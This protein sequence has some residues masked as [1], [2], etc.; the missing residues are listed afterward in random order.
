MKFKLTATALAMALTM[1][2]LHADEPMEPAPIAQDTVAAPHSKAAER[3]PAHSPAVQE[4]GG[5]SA[6]TA[7]AAKSRKAAPARKVA[8]DYAP[9]QDLLL[10]A[11]SLIGVKYKWGGST[12]E[13]GLDCSGFIRYV[14]QN[15][16]NITLPHNALGMSRIGDDINRNELK[17]GDLVFF[18]TLKRKFSHV[19]IYLGDG[20]FIH[21]P[22]TGRNIEVANMGDRYWT[23]RFDG[24]RRMSELDHENIDVNAL[25]Q[26]KQARATQP[27]PVAAAAPDRATSEKTCRKVTKVR[28]GKKT[29]STVCTTTKPTVKKPAAKTVVKGKPSGKKTAVT[30]STTKKKTVPKKKR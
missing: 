14:F 2:G 28:K 11:M 22:R 29:T 9:A 17:P 3:A 20:R 12:P 23:S 7:P 15:S 21:S 30:R 1:A 16:L 10:S 19:G 24:A 13:S 4:S 8:S 18:N 27:A 25:L 5:T 6:E 26:G